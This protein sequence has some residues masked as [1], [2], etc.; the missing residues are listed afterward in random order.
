MR[1]R[2]LG[3]WVG[4]LMGLLW[5]CMMGAPDPTHASQP[6]ALEMSRPTPT[7]FKSAFLPPIT[8]VSQ[9]EP[10]RCPKAPRSR[11]I[12]SERAR[13]TNNDQALNIRSYPG[14]QYQQIGQMPPGSVFFVLSG[15]RCEGDYVWFYILYQTMEGWIAEGDDDVTYAV[16]YLDG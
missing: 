6:E 3:V 12:V 5:G 15:P 13:V 4:V 7:I 16:P 2:W 1:P 10:R 14:T 11:L 9:A 8:P